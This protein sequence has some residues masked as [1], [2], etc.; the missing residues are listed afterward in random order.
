MDPEIARRAQQAQQEAEEAEFELRIQAKLQEEENETQRLAA[1]EEARCKRAEIKAKYEQAAVAPRQQQRVLPSQSTAPP[2]PPPASSSLPTTKAAPEDEDD[3]CF[4]MFGDQEEEVSAKPAASSNRVEVN[5]TEIRTDAEGYGAITS[6]RI[7]GGRYQVSGEAGKGVFSTVLR[8]LDLQ[9]K[10]EVV[11]KVARLNEAM[12]R[13]G[14]KEIEYLRLL[15]KMDPEN[16]FCTLRLLDS[17]E[18]QDFLCL[19]LEALDI[20]LRETVYLYGHGEG[21]SLT[22]VRYYGKR[23]LMGLYHMKQCGLVHTDLKLDNLLI[24]KQRKVLKVADFGS[25][26]RVSEFA[27]GGTQQLCPMWYRPP[28]VIAG[29]PYLSYSLDMWC[30]G[31][32]LFELA[33]GTVL[34][35]G[36]SLTE[37][38]KMYIE[39]LGPLPRKMVREADVYFHNG[40]PTKFLDM[41]DDP[42]T[43]RTLTTIL[44][45]TNQP[46]QSLKKKIF[47]FF[48][49][50][51]GEERKQVF[52]LIDLI[53]KCLILNPRKRLPCD[54]ALQ[55]PFFGEAINV[56]SGK[57]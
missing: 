39:L 33:T 36:N 13:A 49:D 5:A 44:D 46:T 6:G 42:V 34:F 50:V 20:S 53:G 11:V 52:H 3:D 14:R 9:T 4:D 1:L 51:H 12:K 54:E 22:A 30:L 25:T 15:T 27:K 31:N 37:Q 19:V 48:P 41:H 7:L 40:D 32:I 23:V 55:H 18:D 45:M 43:G 2:P 56:D 21:L 38:M 8:C 17:F 57:K 29:F 47:D 16:K 35:Q 10:T 26:C 28:E 24:D